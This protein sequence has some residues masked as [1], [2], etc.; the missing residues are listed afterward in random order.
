MGKR[1]S[2]TKQKAKLPSRAA[3]QQEWK[4]KNIDHVR[5]RSRL[6]YK[7]NKLRLREQK[8][9]W[10]KSKNGRRSEKKYYA[11]KGRLSLLLLRQRKRKEVLDHLGGKCQQCGYSDYRALQIDHV[12]GKGS[13][14]RR[15]LYKSS[16]SYK[17]YKR[18]KLDKKN[19]YQ[20]LC[21][22]CNWIKYADAVRN[23]IIKNHS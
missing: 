5:N 14:E 2:V 9:R 8:S 10:R 15:R 23:S 7:K 3:Y 18:V 11:G 20:I 17:F 21:A 6:Y 13:R 16:A 22:N 12:N 4:K 1:E 19:R